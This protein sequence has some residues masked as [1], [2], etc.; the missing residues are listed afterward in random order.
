MHTRTKIVCTIG[1][2][3]NSY[4][5]IVEL[6]DAGMNVARLNFS[7][8][9]HQDHLKVIEILKRQEGRKKIPLGIMLDT[10]GPEIRIGKIQGDPLPVSAAEKE[11]LTKKNLP[12]LP[13]QL[14][15][16]PSSVIDALQEGM[17]ILFDD[18]YLIAE[19]KEKHPEG[20]WIQCM[21]ERGVALPKGSQ[22]PRGEHRSSRNDRAGC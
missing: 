11:L 6:I 4:E 1:P 18:G 19:V 7:H 14:T 20:V 17:K 8:G 9:T 16:V 2:A 10:K 3:V 12:D 5:K 21:N 22:S 15:I 13:K